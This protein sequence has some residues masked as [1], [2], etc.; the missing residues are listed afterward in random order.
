MTVCPFNGRYFI[1]SPCWTG[2]NIR[3]AC[4]TCGRVE[5][6]L[7]RW[8]QSWQFTGVHRVVPSLP[9]TNTHCVRN[10]LTALAGSRFPASVSFSSIPHRLIASSGRLR[11]ALAFL[12]SPRPPHNTWALEGREP[13]P[14][15]LSP[16][17]DALWRSLWSCRSVAAAGA[18]HTGE[19]G[20]T[21]RQRYD[22]A[23][24]SQKE[25]SGTDALT[26]LLRD[27]GRCSDSLCYTKCPQQRQDN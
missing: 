22:A 15:Y 10:P 14:A 19:A 17:R 9:N 26:T 1:Y 2:K 4:L 18:H 11:V 7:Q 12:P 21:R 6:P 5:S 25:N 8:R 13:Q 23:C 27:R 3:G 24:T 20:S 16:G